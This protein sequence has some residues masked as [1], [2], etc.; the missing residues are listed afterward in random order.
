MEDVWKGDVRVKDVLGEMSGWEMSR[1]V[2]QGDSRWDIPG[3][4]SRWMMSRGDVLKPLKACMLIKFS[5]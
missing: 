3:E 4:M 1:W 2:N 5:P